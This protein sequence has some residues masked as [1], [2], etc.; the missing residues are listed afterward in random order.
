MFNLILC[1]SIRNILEM[2]LLSNIYNLLQ[3]GATFVAI[4]FMQPG[5][6]GKACFTSLEVDK[7]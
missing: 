3:F 4:L 1:H 5:V 2:L 6:S 7:M